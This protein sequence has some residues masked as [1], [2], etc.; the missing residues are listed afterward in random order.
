MSTKADRTMFNSTAR[1]LPLEQKADTPTNSQSKQLRLCED[2]GSAEFEGAK[3]M[4]EI[5]GGASNKTP[6]GKSCSDD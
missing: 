6:K 5:E 4:D 1:R 3:L 2:A